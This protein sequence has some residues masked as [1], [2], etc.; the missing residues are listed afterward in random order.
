MNAATS[1]KERGDRRGERFSRRELWLLVVLASIQFTSIVDFVIMMPLGPQF[2]QVF[3][4]TPRQFGHVVSAYGLSAGVS[5]VL[6]GFLLDRIDRKKALLLVYAGFGLG[7]LCC[8]IAPRYDILAVAR[9][10]AGAFGGVTGAVIMAIIADAIPESRRGAAMGVVMSS[11]SVASVVGVPAGLY[12]ATHF[13]WHSPFFALAGLSGLI[14]AAAARALPKMDHHVA[15]ALEVKPW[16]FMKDLFSHGSHQLALVFMAALTFASFFINPFLSTYMVRNA[17]FREGDLGWMYL[18][19]G[20]ATIFTM[21]LV[22]R[23]SDRSGKRPVF[24]MVALASVVP[25]LWLSRLGVV[26]LAVGLAGTTLYM[27]CMSGRMVP[28]MAMLT[29]TVIPRYRGSFMSLNAAVQHLSAGLASDIAGSVLVDEPR[30]GRLLGFGWLGLASAA[31]TI[32]GVALS[33]KLKPAGKVTASEG[34]ALA[35]GEGVELM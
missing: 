6:A 15:K 30:T 20:L 21:N 28:A 26:P 11:F 23:W 4:I 31:L 29:S 25:T 35:A 8:A 2:M 12:L 19:G 18:A 22:G 34:V 9:A 24:V 5:G 33:L 1:R 3:H 16:P 14:L 10:V 13:G 17:G 27:I 32:A 7:T